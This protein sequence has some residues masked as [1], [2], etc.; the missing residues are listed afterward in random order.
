[1]LTVLLIIFACLGGLLI[2]RGYKGKRRG[3]EPRCRRC[4]YDLRGQIEPRC[5]E[6]GTPFSEAT[7][8]RGQRRRRPWRIATGWLF[9]SL[10]AVLIAPPVRQYISTTLGLAA[11]ERQLIGRWRWQ[12]VHYLP[13]SMLIRRLYSPDEFTLAAAT[14]ALELRI[15]AGDVTRKEMARMVDPVIAAARHLRETRSDP[16]FGMET[17][18]RELLDADVLSIEQQQRYFGRWITPEYQVSGH[19]HEVLRQLH[20]LFPYQV[21]HMFPGLMPHTEVWLL[22]I[23]GVP[24]SHVL[25]FSCGAWSAGHFLPRDEAP[26]YSLTVRISTTWYFL[27]RPAPPERG[28]PA[29]QL[30][31]LIAESQPRMICRLVKDVRYTPPAEYLGPYFQRWRATILAEGEDPATM[32]AP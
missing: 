8:R 15:Q 3:D 7:V 17:I 11:W 18:I 28:T 16:V 19:S 31:A 14:R 29:V 9:V 10:A 12:H 6:C 27:N 21:S 23:D 24:R 4:D 22:D 32:P 20:Q 2:W 5:P 1:M 30:R 26:E 13:T 25:L